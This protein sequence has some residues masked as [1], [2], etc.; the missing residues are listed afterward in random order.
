MNVIIVIITVLTFPIGFMFL[1][2]A[3]KTRNRILKVYNFDK[4][5]ILSYYDYMGQTTYEPNWSIISNCIAKNQSGK[6]SYILK[7]VANSLNSE[8]AF[9][10]TEKG[11]GFRIKD[12]WYY[13]RLHQNLNIVLSQNSNFIRTAFKNKTVVIDYM[14]NDKIP[15]VFKKFGI[16]SLLAIAMNCE[17]EKCILCIG[18]TKNLT[19]TQ[20]YQVSYTRSDIELA[21]VISLVMVKPQ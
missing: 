7:E 6:E 2:N 10:I 20:P 21:E 17:K 15:P 9:I 12:N 16:K 14:L 5:N 3:L 13:S 8:I 1:I 4:E 18:N 19:G 11:D